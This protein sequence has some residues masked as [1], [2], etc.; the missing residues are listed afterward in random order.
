MRPLALGV[1]Q[2]LLC[3]LLLALHRDERLLHLAEPLARL[4]LLGL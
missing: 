2:C 3:L 1:I 4:T